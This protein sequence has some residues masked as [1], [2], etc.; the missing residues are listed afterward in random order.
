[1]SQ[2]REE[3]QTAINR[4]SA[5]NESGT[6]DFILASF[7]TDSLQAF[8]NATNLRDRWWGFNPKIGGTIPAKGPV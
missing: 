4:A 1:M 7:L 3:I 2:L 8:D 6:P 5:E